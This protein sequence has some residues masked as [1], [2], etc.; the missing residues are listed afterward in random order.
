MTHAVNGPSH[1]G[2]GGR[3]ALEISVVGSFSRI[4]PAVRGAPLRVG[5][6]RARGPGRAHRRRD[7]ADVGPRPRDDLGAGGPRR[8]RRSWSVVSESRS[9]D[10]R[11]GARRGT[12]GADRFP[13]VVAD[14]ASLAP[15]ATAVDRSSRPSRA[16]TSWSTTPARSMRRG[17]RAQ[18]GIEAT[19]ALMVVGPFALEA[20]PRAAPRARRRG[21]A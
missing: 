9:S 1:V 17:T 3:R 4:G 14:L 2:D 5:R 15:C 7:R 18:D 6:P 8:A 20:W 11:D 10:L 19:L 21:R 12:S 16:S 13:V